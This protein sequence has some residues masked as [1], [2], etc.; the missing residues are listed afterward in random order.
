MS[1]QL[2]LQ[3]SRCWDRPPTR[4]GVVPGRC[5]D[6]P[7]HVRDVLS[8]AGQRPVEPLPPSRG[9]R[10][11][12]YDGHNTD[13]AIHGLWFWRITQL[14]T[15]LASFQ[16]TSFIIITIVPHVCDSGQ[17]HLWIWEGPRD[18][19]LALS[20]ITLI[21]GPWWHWGEDSTLPDSLPLTSRDISSRLLPIDSYAPNPMC[22]IHYQS[23]TRLSSIATP[24]G[25]LDS[26]IHV[27][28]C[29]K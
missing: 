13:F 12:T 27:S 8:D 3:V 7:S 25:H 15:D 17:S 2:L 29:L 26:R 20:T 24:G 4:P 6:G 1:V 18:W 19:P 5:P 28:Q 14:Q 23:S 11:R 16:W 22:S 21:Q 9:E 10:L